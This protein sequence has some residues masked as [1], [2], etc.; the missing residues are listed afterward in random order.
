VNH[1]DKLGEISRRNVPPKV[2]IRTGIG[3]EFP[4]NPGYQHT[5]D[6]TIAFKNLCKNINLV[7]LDHADQIYPEYQE[8]LSRKDG[9]STL[10]VEWGDE[11]NE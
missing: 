8:A 4:P 3:S 10:L 11:Y 9:I 5:G 6:F 7:R 2:I 1:L